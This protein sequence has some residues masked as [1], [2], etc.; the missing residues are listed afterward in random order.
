M[1]T[2]RPD[3][4]RLARAA[5]R[6]GLSEAE[7]TLLINYRKMGELI[8]FLRTGNNERAR[9]LAVIIRDDLGR[10]GGRLRDRRDHDLPEPR[11][12]RPKEDTGFN[13]ARP[14]WRPN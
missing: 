3:P 7:S 6:S 13:P 14:Q 9:E 5:L 12:R 10:V 4:V 8:E 11:T 2:P 1:K